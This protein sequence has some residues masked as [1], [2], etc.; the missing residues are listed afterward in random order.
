MTEPIRHPLTPAQQ[1]RIAATDAVIEKEQAALR[2]YVQA[3]ADGVD[4]P[5]GTTWVVRD[6]H[7]VG[8]PPEIP[9]GGL[10]PG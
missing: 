6:G 4:A 7:L 10:A 8:T 2:V 9:P 1:R 3:I 5:D